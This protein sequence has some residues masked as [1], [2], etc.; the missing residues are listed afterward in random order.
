MISNK[1]LI[2]IYKLSQKDFFEHKDQKSIHWQEYYSK[3]KFEDENNLINFRKKRM[4][5]SGMDDAMNLQNNLNL[6]EVLD[7]F[8]QEFLKKN[9]PTKNIGNSNFSINFLGFY[10]DYGIVH[11]LKWFEEISKIFSTLCVISLKRLKLE[12]KFR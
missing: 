9:L 6:I 10:F 4:L 8:D 12:I 3:K 5:S 2:E 7:F 1:E 11:H